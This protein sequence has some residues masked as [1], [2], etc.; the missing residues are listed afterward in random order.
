MDAFEVHRQL[1][2]DYR[3]FTEGF[4]EIR[5]DRLRAHLQQQ[6]SKDT[7]WPPPWLGLNPSFEPGGRINELVDNGL[8]HPECAR[9]FQKD[10]PEAGDG[11]KPLTLHKHQ[12]DAIKAAREGHS[13]VLTTGTGSGKSLAY[14]VPI[15]DHVLRAGSG[16]GIKAIVVYPMNALA[17]SQLE[18]LGKFLT[19]GYGKGNEPVRFERYTGQEDDS[20]RQ[21]ILNDPPDIL[22]TNYVM[23]ELVLT[24]PDER[25]KLIEQARGLQ[26][27]VLDELH[28]YRG[29]QGADVAML[30][31]RVR[32]ACHADD[33]LQVVGTSA[34]MSGGETQQEQREEVADVASKIFG[35]T[36]EPVNVI[37]ETLTRVAPKADSKRE[38]LAQIVRSRGEPEA[39]DP[40]LR[41]DF[42]VFRQDLLVA[43]IEASFGITEEPGNGI[44]VRRTPRTVEQAA[45]DLSELTGQPQTRCATAIRA[46][47]LAG[48]RCKDPETN[49][50]LFAFRLHQFLSKGGSIYVTAEPE[51][52]RAIETEFQVELPGR[53]RLYPLAF[54]RECGQEYLVATREGGAAGDTKYRARHGLRI[55]E[56]GDGYLFISGERP[57]PVDYLAENRLPESWIESVQ[58]APRVVRARRDDVPQRVFVTP[59][60]NASNSDADATLAAWIPGQFRFCLSCGVSY[61]AVRSSELAKLV[62][63][64]REGRSS[65]MSVIATS[66]LRSLRKIDDPEFE[67]EARK[68]LTFVDN[69]QDASLQAGHF[70]DFALVAQLRSAIYRAALDMAERGEPLTMDDL[71]AAVTGAL[72][73]APT[74]YA[75][76]PGTIA[77]LGKAERALRRVVEY[78]ALCDLQYGWRFTL[79]NLE[80]TGLLGVDYEGLDKLVSLDDFWSKIDPRLGNAEPAVRREIVTVLFD[81][82]RRFLALDSFV[83]TVDFV[84]RLQR[85]S[86]DLLMGLWTVS[87][88]EPPPPIGLAVPGPGGKGGPRHALF[89]SGRGAY[90]RWLGD[91]Q[92]FGVKL[93]S[94]EVTE[95]IQ[96]LL[97][98]LH[99]QGYLTEVADQGRK[100]YRLSASV[101]LLRPG[102]GDFGAAS[103]LRQRF[104]GDRKP[105]VVPFFRDLYR[106][107]ARELAGFRAAEHTAQVRSEERQERERE[108]SKAE[109]PLLFCS[110]TMELG[111]DIRSLNTVALRNVPPTP[112][113]YAQRS[114][115]AGRSGQ[116]A[117]VVTYCASGNSHDTYYFERSHLMVSGKVQAPRLDLANEDLIRSHVQALWL[118]ET[119]E[120]L[121]RSMEGLLNLS[122]NGYPLRDELR[123]ALSDPDAGRRAKQSAARLL[124]PLRAQ[125]SKQAWWHDQWAEEAIDGVV[126]QFD[127]KCNRWRQLYR[128]VSAELSE[129]SG[130]AQDASATAK[131]RSDADQRYREARQRMELLL[132]QSA[133]T[134]QTDF[135]PYRYLASEGFLP[136]YSFPRLPLAAYIPG[137]RGKGNTWLQRPRFLAL[138]EFGPKA[139]IYHEG[140]RYEVIR[141][142][143]PRGKD[144]GEAGEVV[145]SEARVCDACGYYH[146]R[147]DGADVCE[148]CR[149]RLGKTFK[150]L[151]QMQTVVTRRRERISADEEERNRVGFEMLTSY[152]FIPRGKNPGFLDAAV[153]HGGITIADITYGDAAEIRIINLGRRR[154]KIKERHGFMLDLVKGMWLKEADDE[155]EPEDDPDGEP[156]AEDV[157]TKGRVIPFVEDRRNM[158][159]FRWAEAVDVPSGD[160]VDTTTS[161]TLQFALERGIEAV[162]QLEDA[163]LSSEALPDDELRG[164]T[165]FIEAAEGGAGVLRRLQSAEEDDALARAAREAMNIIH[166]DPESGDDREDA[167]VRGCYRCLLS[168]GN[169]GAHELI[170]RRTAVP[171][172]MKLARSTVSEKETTTTPPSPGM[173]DVSSESAATA[174]A[175]ELLEL[176]AERDLRQPTKI[177][178]QV[179]G[180][181]GRIDFVF[182]GNGIT[183]AVIIETPGADHHP[184]TGTLQ[185]IKG[186]NVLW[187]GA[188]DD[189]EAVVASNPTVFG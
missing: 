171:H 131:D 54:C 164:R 98:G 101:I 28:T 45:E 127:D 106:D 91:A 72:N 23:L 85:E 71:G 46:T 35:T 20:E 126:T 27:L 140:A 147:Q 48:S 180:F 44:L 37:T 165:M 11:G 176:I 94:A 99:E 104:E 3:S 96:N 175:R 186:W 43:W 113:N 39:D 51:S 166:V 185:W 84:E 38:Q 79:P 97:L 142:N 170:D 41:S 14:I 22:L 70:N 114:G 49:R 82:L 130:Q 105:R 167:C 110:P 33:T 92:R 133:T 69:R 1:V 10:K 172:L 173:T 24:R 187:V 115:R 116:P 65:A 63:L 149:S 117:L 30:V 128:T 73:L 181:D 17:N 150:Q 135:W 26:F 184:D 31:R 36:I 59:E 21:R 179:E 160:G 136:G 75:R 118:A 60:G 144:G 67:R 182:E 158:L 141:I 18:E 78:R 76:S 7:Q 34:T 161:I 57:W 83:L 154:R 25:R 13:Y 61:E 124:E 89:L 107:T 19:H 168:Y 12:L 174:R 52:D 129:A 183:T 153:T 122:E 40:V 120:P 132:N 151:M 50:P 8:L 74:D 42:D 81:E 9:I 119:G 5:D 6:V 86:S 95:I 137:M 108:F 16:R 163:E 156:K 88:R 64:D 109:L 56:K 87:D 178:A 134:G 53:R 103:P 102:P 68:L 32:D 47:L 145:T 139:L 155:T 93:S 90:G 121:G 177:N 188:D 2:A 125:L 143:L 146:D 162:F 77:L 15:V 62:T 4:V 111:V 189:L 29:R 66:V 112:A 169:Q 100:G 123:A 138:S 80:Q 55:T 58:T 152:R 157:K 148:R 159:V